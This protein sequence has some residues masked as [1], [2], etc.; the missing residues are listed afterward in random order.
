M[1]LWGR[2]VEP[3]RRRRNFDEVWN[4]WVV[5]DTDP[6]C[7]LRREPHQDHRREQQP[8]RRSGCLY[9]KLQ[10]SFD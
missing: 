10:R 3:R 4:Y 6:L 2:G 1:R 7:R 8:H 9:K 5:K